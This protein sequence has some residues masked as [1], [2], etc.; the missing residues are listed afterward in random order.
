MIMMEATEEVS[1]R[2][3]KSNK[4]CMEVELEGRYLHPGEWCS[5]H[6]VRIVVSLHT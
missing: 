1:R 3:I 6:Y 2:S 4:V 5:V